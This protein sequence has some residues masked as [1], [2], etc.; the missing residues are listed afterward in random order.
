MTVALQFPVFL[1]TVFVVGPVTAGPLDPTSARDTLKWSQ[2]QGALFPP[3]L[4]DGMCED[5]SGLECLRGLDHLYFAG[6]P[7][8]RRTAEKLVD[9]VSVKPAM[10]SSEAGA[11]FLQITG[12]DDWEF[13]SFR[14]GMGMEMQQTTDD[15][16]EAVFTRRPDLEQWQQVF[17]VYPDLDQFHTHDLFSKHPSIAGSW[18]YVGRTD[19]MVPFSHG[20]NLYVADMEAEITAAHPA[21]TAVLIG[22]QGKP[23]PYLLIEWNGNKLDKEAKREQL[24]PVIEHANRG[25]SNLVKLQMDF[26]LFTEPEKK[27]VRTAKGSVSRRESEKLYAEK[28]EAL[29][30]Q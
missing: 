6:A 23:N 29:Y 17:K 4:I 24:L 27:L 5:P 21:I 10:G 11:Y 12:K 9:Y 16:Y 3:A 28:I 30:H 2:A 25:C 1:G 15:L 7:L 13:Y 20:E 14:P 26:T 18:K 19:D 22:G 8:A